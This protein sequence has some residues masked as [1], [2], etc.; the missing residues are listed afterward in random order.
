MVFPWVVPEI[1]GRKS[2]SCDDHVRIVANKPRAD[3]RAAEAWY[4]IH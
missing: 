4:A 3:G 2:T 1:A